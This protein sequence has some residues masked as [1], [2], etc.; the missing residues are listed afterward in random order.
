MAAIKNKDRD[1]VKSIT[2][3]VMFS[4]KQVDFVNLIKSGKNSF[5]SKIEFL[6]EFYKKNK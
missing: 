5:S 3:G 4:K 6:I 2:K 1:S